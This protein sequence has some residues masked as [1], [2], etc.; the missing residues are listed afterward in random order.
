M[1]GDWRARNHPGYWAFL[2]HRLSGLA[3][4]LFLPAHFLVLGQALRGEAALAGV[5]RWTEVPLVKVAEVALVILLAAH[6]TGGARLLALEFLP[7]RN[8]Q[9]SLAAL[10]AGIALAFGLAYALALL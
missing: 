5:L 9:K 7:W 1:R 6:L 8:W 4:A 10:A 3:L 2:V